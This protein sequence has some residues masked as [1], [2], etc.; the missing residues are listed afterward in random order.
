MTP[1]PITAA[2]IGAALMGKGMSF[3]PVVLYFGAIAV[4]ALIGVW[5]APE[6]VRK[7]LD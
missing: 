7:A 1:T 2:G 4:L 5:L 3:T 6:S